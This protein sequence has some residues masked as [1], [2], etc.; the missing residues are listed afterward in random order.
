LERDDDERLRRGPVE[1]NRV[2]GAHDVTPI[3]HHGFHRGTHVP[4][5]EAALESVSVGY[6]VNFHDNEDRLYG[7][8]VQA[9]HRRGRKTAGRCGQRE[10]K[11]AF[12]NL[13][14]LLNLHWSYRDG[15]A[16]A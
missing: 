1:S 4:S 2:L 6:L 9:A 10:R 16:G 5:L 12:H 3:L 15:S 13:S 11:I 7:R 14:P 8:S